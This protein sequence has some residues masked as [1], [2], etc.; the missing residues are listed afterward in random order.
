MQKLPRVTAREV[1]ASLRRGGWTLIR[2]EGSHVRLAHPTRSGRVTVAMHG[3]T[4]PPK[5][6]SSILKQAGL[7]VDEFIALL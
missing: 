2:Q 6:L 7:S 1:V 5:T 3:G 4:L